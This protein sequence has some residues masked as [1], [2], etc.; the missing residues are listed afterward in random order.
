MK[1]FKEKLNKILDEGVQVYHFAPKTPTKQAMER[2]DG[3]SSISQLA[4]FEKAVEVIA[5]DLI[6]DGFEDIDVRDYLYTIM[7]DKLA[8]VV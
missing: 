7:Q 8:K 4:A 5:K 2:M 3:L 6:E 1:E